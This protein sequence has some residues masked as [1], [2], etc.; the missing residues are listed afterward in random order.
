[1]IHQFSSLVNRMH[2][3]LHLYFPTVDFPNQHFSEVPVVLYLTHQHREL[4]S[5]YNFRLTEMRNHT[6]QNTGGGPLIDAR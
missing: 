3:I 6:V 4:I 5:F 2:Y 1:M